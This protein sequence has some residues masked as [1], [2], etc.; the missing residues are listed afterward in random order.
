MSIRPL[1]SFTDLQGDQAAWEGREARHPVRTITRLT[2][3]SLLNSIG[4]LVV[5]LAVAIVLR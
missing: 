4:G 3:R 2:H 5:K 1:R